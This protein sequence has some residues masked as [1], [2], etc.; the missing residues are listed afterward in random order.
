MNVLIVDD[1]YS[2]RM[3]L[4]NMLKK[5]CPEVTLIGQA[6]SV[7]AAYPMI[8]QTKPNLVFLDVK[9]PG[10]NGFDLLRMFDE[11]NFFVVF[12]TGFDEYAIQA[13]E[14][15]AIDYV[16]KPIDHSK[17]IMAVEKAKARLLTNMN[18]VIH[19]VHSLEEKTNYVKQ[20][21]IHS[22]DKVNVVDL[23]D[24]VCISAARG[25]CEI[26]T[27]KNQKFISAKPLSDYEELLNP[28]RQFIRVNKSYLI[29]STHINSY[30]KGND[31]VIFMNG[32][33]MEIEV[34]RRK[35]TEV[36]QLIKDGG[37]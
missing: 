25:Y 32:L 16:L 23:V 6:D 14:F 33:D 30:T 24:I 8:L 21:T 7:D 10:K 11:I 26:Y 18:N 2:N 9:M 1:E 29:N 36:L 17:L 15:N 12:V 20:I 22:K 35:K 27:A 5:H 19:F 3:L 31:C 28:I 37:G 34:G 13:F 4:A